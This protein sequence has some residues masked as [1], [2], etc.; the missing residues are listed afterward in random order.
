MRKSAISS[1]PLG[2]GSTIDAP[3]VIAAAVFYEGH[4]WDMIFHGQEHVHIP[5][6][7]ATCGDRADPG[8]HRLGDELRRG[9]HQRNQQKNHLFRRVSLSL[10]RSLDPELTLT[11]PEKIEPPMGYVISLPM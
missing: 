8:G 3:K 9:Y 1:L 7:G 5:T 11:V 6:P 2:G 10:C 4:P